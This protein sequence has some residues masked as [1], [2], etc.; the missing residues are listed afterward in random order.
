M[1]DTVLFDLDGTIVHHG[2][3]LMPE[4]LAEWGYI[5]DYDAVKEAV[6]RSIHHF[7]NHITQAEEQGWVR[8]LI[9]EFYHLTLVELEI[10]DPDNTRSYAMQA[11]FDT[12]PVP[13]LF[14]DIPPVLDSLRGQGH[15]LGIITQRGRIGATRF[16]EE[17]GIHDYFDVL[18]AG[19]DGHGRKPTAG[20]FRQ[21][22]RTLG[23]EEQRA[24]YI[25][26]RIDDDCEGARGA[27]LSGAFLI[28]RDEIFSLEA[29]DRDD[30]VHLTD[31]RQL[32]DHLP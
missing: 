3:A 13:P 10:A 20:P 11:F 19:D 14:D 6:A 23:K 26:D 25:G 15:T 17:H 27:G 7:Y 24:I 9:R 2:N 22:L 16:L 8:D 31:M 28:D 21:A 30:F 1:I 4:L 32:L 12:N 18:I 5:R 29:A